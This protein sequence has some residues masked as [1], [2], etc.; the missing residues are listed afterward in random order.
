MHLQNSQS[1]PLVSF[2]F[3]LRNKCIE[4]NIVFA[5]YHCNICN[6]WMG[7]GKQPFHCDKCGFCRVG[8]AE[9]YTHCDVCCM[10]LDND[11]YGSHNCLADKY[12]NNC[13]VCRLVMCEYNFF[14]LEYFLINENIICSREDMHTS[15]HSPQDL[16]CGHAIH[17][18]CFRK[19]AA[20]DYR[21]PICKKTVSVLI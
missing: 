2:S 6:L 11:V 7:E 8:G 14:H 20:F 17:S 13:P 5:D 1:H 3:I 19:L 10:C 4:C 21:C 9:N 16:P 12:K 15:R 18:V